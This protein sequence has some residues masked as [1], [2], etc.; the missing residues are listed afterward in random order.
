MP[1]YVYRC[2]VHGNFSM[3]RRIDERDDPADCP[4]CR[5]VAERAVDEEGSSFALKG[6][7]WYRDGYK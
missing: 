6:S 1:I 2:P 5:R 3:L 4:E 7:G